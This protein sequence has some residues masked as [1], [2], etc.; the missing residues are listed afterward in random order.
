M[1]NVALSAQEH[2]RKF[3]QENERRAADMVERKRNR[4]KPVDAAAQVPLQSKIL[5]ST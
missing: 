5:S 2:K 1:T 4:K 3:Q